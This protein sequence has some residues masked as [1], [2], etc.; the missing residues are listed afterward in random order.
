MQAGGGVW[1]GGSAGEP[2]QTRGFQLWIALPPKLEL[3]PSV[4]L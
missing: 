2:G 3:G 1:H 4:S